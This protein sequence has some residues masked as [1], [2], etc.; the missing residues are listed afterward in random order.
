MR[1]GVQLLLLLL[2]MLH[3]RHSSA[4]EFDLA[5]PSY[6][7]PNLDDDVKWTEGQPS[8]QTFSQ[9]IAY[10]SSQFFWFTNQ[11]A[12]R[13]YHQRQWI[14]SI[15]VTQRLP[16]AKQSI[17]LIPYRKQP[18]YLVSPQPNSGMTDS[19][20]LKPGFSTKHFQA[21]TNHEASTKTGWAKGRDYL[22]QWLQPALVHL[23]PEKNPKT[24]FFVGL[25]TISLLT[26]A[27]EPYSVHFKV[28]F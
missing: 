14:A 12:V 9:S 10:F 8:P 20:F 1:W 6:H 24:V 19:H 21:K 26:Y 2:L 3:Y 28:K 4:F 27:E 16:V 11:A 13:R 7:Q 25:L 15:A 22:R 23:A 18:L 17:W 5:L